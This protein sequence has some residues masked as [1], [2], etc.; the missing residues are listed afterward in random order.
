MAVAIA[1]LAWSL[2][3]PFD[4]ATALAIMTGGQVYSYRNAGRPTPKTH[5][6]LLAALICV[7]LAWMW[8]GLITGFSGGIPPQAQSSVAILCIASFDLKTRRN[9]FIMLIYSLLLLY[10]ACDS[11]FSPWLLLFLITYGVAA[12]TALF[13]AALLDGQ[14]VAL[15]VIGRRPS[16]GATLYCLGILTLLAFGTIALFVLLPRPANSQLL[17]SPLVSY[18]LRR[19]IR[20]QTV[21]PLFPFVSITTSSAGAKEPQ[22]SL[23]YRGKPGQNIVLYV[24]SEIQSYWRGLALDEYDGQSWR[25]TSGR[26]LLVRQHQGWFDLEVPR[27]AHSGTEYVQS[28]TVVQEGAEVLLT[29][30]WPK[31]VHHLSPTVILEGGLGGTL[32]DARA[33]STGTSYAV[34][35]RFPPFAPQ[36]LR[37]DHAAHPDNRYTQLPALSPAVRRL[38]ES[39]TAGETTDIDRVQAL[40]QFLQTNFRYDLNIPPLPPQRDATEVF[41]FD[42]KRGFCQQFATALAVLTRSIGIPSRIVTGYLPGQYQPL[43][44]AF[45]VVA[46]DAHSWVEVHFAEHGWVPFD[47][48]PSVGGD[49]R[50]Q[51]RASLLSFNW[52]ADYAFAL[53]VTFQHAIGLVTTQFDSISA[54]FAAGA[55]LALV[56]ALLCGRLVWQLWTRSRRRQLTST[57]VRPDRTHYL[58]G[59]RLLEQALMRGG[60]PARQLWETPKEHLAR[61]ALIFPKIEQELAEVA[62][63]ISEIA[64]AAQEPEGTLITMVSARIADVI[65]KIGLNRT[66]VDPFSW[67]LNH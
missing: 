52:G 19:E 37:K 61:S 67:T 6:L 18:P 8:V 10:I 55:L 5:S 26:R 48:T 47:A 29:G 66:G 30:Y 36:G 43:L 59:Y 60:S 32:I 50:A 64:Y 20:G 65:A 56:S 58:A 15:A 21:T 33:L 39:V 11:T 45:E 4:G 41:L 14:R 35:S 63:T 28:F 62:T 34:L 24:R 42:D 31:T 49:P 44:G 1:G 2:G 57:F 3:V 17:G 7:S 22:M 16:L 27:S 25:S 40:V 13:A 54:G 51:W 53:G 12:L 23:A 46:S 38:A 9:L